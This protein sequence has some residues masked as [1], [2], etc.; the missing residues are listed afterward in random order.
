MLRSKLKSC[1][2]YTKCYAQNRNKNIK[3][4]FKYH[5]HE[6]L[7]KHPLLISPHS[8]QLN[9]NFTHEVDLKYSKTCLWRTCYIA[10]DTI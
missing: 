5:Q 6:I 1:R 10:D 8:L 9:C 2:P 3:N 7:L 4:H